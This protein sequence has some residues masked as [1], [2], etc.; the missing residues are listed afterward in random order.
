[1]TVVHSAY[2]TWK[3]Y[4]LRKAYVY[5][6]SGKERQCKCIIFCWFNSLSIYFSIVSTW[7]FIL[8][9]DLWEKTLSYL[10]VYLF[11][12]LVGWLFFFIVCL[13]E[14]FRPIRE[15]FFTHIKTWPLPVKGCKVWPMLGTHG[16]WTVKV[17][18][19]PNLLW[20]EASVYNGPLWGPLTLTPTA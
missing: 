4:I 20:H 14:V 15:F 2:E 19:V 16:H 18:S 13:F 3:I 1:M 10:F 17:L 11:V 8:T 5:N 12:C 7:F 6:F 9:G